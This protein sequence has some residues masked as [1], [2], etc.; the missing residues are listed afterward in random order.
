MSVSNIK[1]KSNQCLKVNVWS[2]VWCSIHS[3]IMPKF[4]VNRS[5]ENMLT[6]TL[7]LFLFFNRGYYS[8]N[9]MLLIFRC[10]KIRF[11]C[12]QIVSYEKRTQWNL[13][14]K[15]KVFHES[16]SSLMKCYWNCISWNVLKEKI[17]SS[18]LP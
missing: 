6:R 5:S 18:S 7:L 15:A 17:H 14:T 10:Q 11:L 3:K 2:M 16:I 13:Y 4:V 12:K 8:P 1:C 9:L